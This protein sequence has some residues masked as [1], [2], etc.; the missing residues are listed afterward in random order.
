MKT[1][2]SIFKIRF[3][4]GLQYRIA[5]LAGIATQLF[6]GFIFISVYI[7]FFESNNNTNLPMNIQE[8]VDYLWLNQAF[9]ALIYLWMKDKDL[10]S[11]IRNGNIAYEYVRP[12]SFYKKWFTTMYA[13]RLSNVLLRFIP[14]IIIAHALP[15]PFKLRLP[16]SILGFIMF[17]VSIILA[18]LV[19]NTISFIIHLITFYTLDEKGIAALF[20]VIAEI[21]A[22]GTVPIAFF[23]K[24]LKIVAYILPF[25]YT[26]D[27]PF[28]I[29]SGNIT[30]INA[31]PSIIGGI[32][33]LI[34]L[35]FIGYIISKDITK[36]AI[37]QGG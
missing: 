31:L 7:A 11:L 34:I 28:R 17:I 26:C 12:I 23:P 9:L 1:Y 19:V 16:V 4:N 32:I 18:S 24:A 29:Y 27:L 13:N 37:I 36:K 14:V 2:L 10:L 15:S 8:I 33:W 3:I 25:R 5:A 6:F 21:F 22:G 20:M 35:L 30:V